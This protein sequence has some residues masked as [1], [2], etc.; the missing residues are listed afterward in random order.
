MSCGSLFFKSLLRIGLTV[1]IPLRTCLADHL[2]PPFL[3]K[4]VT[5]LSDP[6]GLLGKGYLHFDHWDVGASQ[7]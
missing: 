2:G 7:I 1:D 6:T 3:R 5:I 4:L